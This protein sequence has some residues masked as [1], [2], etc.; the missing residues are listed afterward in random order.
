MPSVS[1]PL[2][3]VMDIKS[4]QD[5]ANLKGLIEEL[6]AKPAG[7]NPIGTAL[8]KL[9][10]VHFARFVFLGGTQF[11]VITDYDGSFEDYIVAFVNAIGGVFDQLLEFMKDAPPL[12]VSS[13][14]PAFMKYVQDHDL[15][16]I[17]PFYSAYPD[18]KVLDIL[19]MQKELGN[20]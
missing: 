13:N 3:L 18:L 11:A 10:M 20:S 1:N 7:Q 19:T 5:F 17:P 14:I 2:T 6:Q 9:S 12:P 16:C 8:T 15:K 4:P